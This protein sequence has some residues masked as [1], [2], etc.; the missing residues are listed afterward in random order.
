MTS[1]SYKLKYR[2]LSTV[3]AALVQFGIGTYP[4]PKEIEL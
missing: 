4:P 3:G 1:L 2:I